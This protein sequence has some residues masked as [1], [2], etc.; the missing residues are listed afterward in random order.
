MKVLLA[1]AMYPPSRAYGGPATVAFQHASAL[2]ARGHEVHVLTTN[3]RTLR[4]GEFIPLGH[5]IEGGVHVHRLPA[6]V[7]S[8]HPTGILPSGISRWFAA[9]ANGF[10]VVHVHFA[11]EIFPVQ[12]V[13]AARKAGLPVAVQ[14]HGMLNRISGPRAALDKLVVRRL[15]RQVDAVF[16]L[17]QHEQSVIQRIQPAA[18]V[19]ILP[20]GLALGTNAPTWALERMKDGHVLFLSRFHSRKRPIAFVEMAAEVARSRPAARFLM[21]GP[22]GGLL[23]ATR[24]RATTLGISSRCDVVGEVADPLAQYAAAAVY[25]LPSIDEPFPMAVLEALAVGTPTIVTTTNH[26]G[27]FLEERGACIVSAPDP[28]S[29]AADVDRVLS[30]PALARSLSDNGRAVIRDDLSIA[31]IARKLE[32]TYDALRQ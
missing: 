7:V 13:N 23:E 19:R 2:I 9:H 4:P 14:P 18:K 32:V 24:K 16:C 28:A 5:A 3:V 17:Q 12:V 20:N 26:V 21:A 22:D 11:R 30:D 10:D 6:R 8:G 27:R 31:S 15:L 29:L 25:V 1:C